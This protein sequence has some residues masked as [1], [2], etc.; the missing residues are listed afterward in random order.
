MR[1]EIC[2]H[3]NAVNFLNKLS[4]K[5]KERLIS[6][7]R[8]LEDRPKLKRAGADIK[9]IRDVD[10]EAYRLRIG[11]YRVIYAVDEDTVWIT[12]I[13]LRGKGYRRR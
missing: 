11:D 12:E 8:V 5:T 10:P 7:M 6:K 13:M 1:Y 4:Q 3:P 2:I 9:K